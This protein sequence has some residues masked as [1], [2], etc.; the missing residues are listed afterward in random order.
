M[1]LTDYAC[2]PVCKTCKE[3]GN[4][5]D[6]SKAS[7]L[8]ADFKA[9]QKVPYWAPNM[10]P[11]RRLKCGCTI[12]WPIIH[13]FGA[14]IDTVICDL[15]GITKLLEDKKPAKKRGKTNDGNSPE[16]DIPPF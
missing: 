6:A 8:L 2:V 4:C 1:I 14:N 3:S 11:D 5:P 10:E 9:D 13:V 16:L 7:V 15:H 12:W